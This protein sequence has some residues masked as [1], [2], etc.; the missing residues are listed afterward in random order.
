[1]DAIHTHGS[2]V[3]FVLLGLG[4]IA[5]PVPEE[6]LLVFSG[7]LIARGDLTIFKTFTAAILGTMCGITV[8]FLLGK[9]AGVFLIKKWGKYIGLSET[10]LIKAQGWFEKAGKWALVVGYFIPGIRH[11]TGY[12]AGMLKLPYPQFAAYAYAGGIAWSSFFLTVGFF[13]QGVWPHLKNFLVH[14][15]TFF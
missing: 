1:M 4:I 11:L 10:R 15:S 2:W 7:F 13:T 8:S 6:T 9:S 14:F 3:I 12:A 5:L